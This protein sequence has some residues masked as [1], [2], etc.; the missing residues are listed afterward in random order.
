MR[1]FLAL[2]LALLAPAICVADVLV[3]TGGVVVA[4]VI[5]AAPTIGGL[6]QVGEILGADPGVWANSPSAY[7]Y[8]WEWLDAGVNIPGATSDAYVPVSGDIGHTLAVTVWASNGAGTSS[9][10][11]S[12]PTAAIAVSSGVPGPSAAAYASPWYACRRNVYVS[13]SGDDATGTGSSTAPWATLQKANDVGRAPGDCVNVAAGTYANGVFL[14]NGGSAATSSGYVVYRCAALD[15]CKITDPNYGFKIV[16][17][18]TGPNYIVIDGFELAAASQQRYGQGVEEWDGL[19]G[20]E[21]A[22]SMHHLWVMNNIIHGYGQ[23]GVNINDGDY[24]YV[25]HNTVYNNAGVTCDAQGSGIGMVVEKAAPNYTPSGMDLTYKSPFHIVVSYNISHD[26]IMTACGSGTDPYDTDGNG[27]I[28]DTFNNAGAGNILYPFQSLVSFNS[29]YNNGAKGIQIFRTSNVTAANNTAYNNNLDPYDTAALRG[30]ITVAGGA[31]NTIINNIAIA[32]PASSGSDA[33][34]AGVDYTVSPWLFPQPCPLQWNSPFGGGTSAGVVD[35]NNSWSNNISLGGPA[36]GIGWNQGPSGNNIWA[37]DSF[38]CAINDCNIDP[39]LVSPSTGNFFLTLPTSPALNF[40]LAESYL[41]ASSVD[42]GAYDRMASGL[43]VTRTAPVISGIVATA[44]SNSASVSWTTDT[45]SSTVVNYGP[46]TS[47][48]TSVS[49]SGLGLAHNLLL[50]KLTPSTT[51]HYVVASTDLSGNT[52]ASGDMVFTTGAYNS[53]VDGLVAY[54]SLDATDI[55][56][57]SVTDLTGNGNVASLTGSPASIPGEV[58][59]ALSFTGTEAL[60][61][62]H[63]A[64]LNILGPFSV[65]IWINP[66]SSGSAGYMPMTRGAYYQATGFGMHWGYGSLAPICTINQ[67]I[68]VSSS[69]QMTAGAWNH[70]ACVYDGATFAVY[71]NGVQTGDVANTV[72]PSALAGTDIIFGTPPDPTPFL[73]GLDQIRIYSRAL[74]A[75]DVAAIVATPQ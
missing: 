50:L 15:A 51:Y 31:G 45:A 48:G 47:Y 73:G 70:V 6:A 44:A 55:A 65:S 41:S 68:A 61:A 27:I 57:A 21:T 43:I 19:S 22:F 4:P 1:K 75:A 56:G 25:L 20:G 3:C 71:V 42:V 5:A 59:Q 14:T 7:A 63:G 54:Y 29:V 72:N 16:A 10:A 23:A 13:A 46:T 60:N 37:A 38:S 28:M 58:G 40:G 66:N 18:G 12:A 35:A 69:V 34:C 2:L 8:Q 62:G 17:S 74:S 9:P 49:G 33:R 32:L 11:V 26:N 64:D 36:L 67:S 30:E 52:T 53:L 39:Q 24:F